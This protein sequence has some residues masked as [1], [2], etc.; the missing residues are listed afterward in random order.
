MAVSSAKALTKA[1]GK[2]ETSFLRRMSATIAKSRGERGQPW[3][4]PPVARKALKVPPPILIKCW[5]STQ[6]LLM[7][8][9][10]KEGRPTWSRT[11]HIK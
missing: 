11:F 5:F 3:R 4:T 10:K 8:L 9:R 7:A 6:N 2:V 1:S